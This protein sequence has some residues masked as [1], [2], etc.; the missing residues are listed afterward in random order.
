M[1]SGFNQFQCPLCGKSVGIKNYDPS[2]FDDD[3]IG[4]RFA[5]LGYGRGFEVAAKGS[6][7]DSDDPVLD[8]I[9]DRVVEISQ[10][11][12]EDEEDD[13]DDRTEELIDDINAVLRPDYDDAA[14]ENLVDAA[15]ALLDR[16]L[17]YDDEEDENDEEED[18]T[19]QYESLSEL[20]KEILLAELEEEDEE[21]KLDDLDDEIVE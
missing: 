18:D 15:E 3:I 20:D 1:D 21:E 13:A 11:L 16:F 10:F 4:I 5:G 12:L 9:A 6:I 2:E 19:G 7:L 14:F 17:D 8:K